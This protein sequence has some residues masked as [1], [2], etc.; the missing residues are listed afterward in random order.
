MGKKN[1]KKVEDID[2][3]ILEAEARLEVLKKKKERLENKVVNYTQFNDL[4]ESIENIAAHIAIREH[5]C[6]YIIKYLDS[7]ELFSP[8]QLADSMIEYDSEGIVHIDCSW[9]SFSFGKY[10]YEMVAP[11][12]GCV[13]I[14]KNGNEYT[15]EP[16][17]IKHGGEIVLENV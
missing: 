14:P 6:I 7:F 8:E 13:I 12:F 9:N 11:F 10:I 17:K 1:D 5:S 15:I 2:F 16:L 3:E 4:P